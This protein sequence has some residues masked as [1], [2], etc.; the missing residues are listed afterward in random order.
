[1]LA[2]LDRWKK[3]D[4]FPNSRMLWVTISLC[5]GRG[6]YNCWVSRKEVSQLEISRLGCTAGLML[7]GSMMTQM[8]SLKC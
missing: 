8:T 3:F 5:K 7:V 6:C 4:I 2:R 1:M